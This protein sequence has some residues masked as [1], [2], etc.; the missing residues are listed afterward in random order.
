MSVG[1]QQHALVKSTFE[2]EDLHILPSLVTMNLNKFLFCKVKL[3]TI[4]IGLLRG[5]NEIIY[6]K[7]AIVGYQYPDLSH[8]T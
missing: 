8:Q 4:P 5:L 2:S 6:I 3:T 7:A 1:H